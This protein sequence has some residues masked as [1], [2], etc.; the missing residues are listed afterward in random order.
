M[1]F[2]IKSSKFSAKSDMT[3]QDL[4]FQANILFFNLKGLLENE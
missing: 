2:C 3:S 1:P 4:A